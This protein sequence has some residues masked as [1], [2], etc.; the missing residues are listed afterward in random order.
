[1]GQAAKPT[2]HNR[3]LTIDFHDETTHIPPRL[4]FNWLRVL[5]ISLTS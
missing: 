2:R 3:T 4:L 1:M 5:L